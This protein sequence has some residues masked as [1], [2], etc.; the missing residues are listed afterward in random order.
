MENK[1]KKLY[2]IGYLTDLLG[3]THRTIRYYEQFGLLPQIK[4]TTGNMRLFDEE[5]VALIKKIR[6][7]QKQEFLPLDVIRDRILGKKTEANTNFIALMDSSA[8][9]PQEVIDEL[10]IK[11]IPLKICYE[12]GEYLDKE[13]IDLKQYK[14]NSDKGVHPQIKG[15][16]ASDLE[17]I[18]LD[19]SKKGYKTIFSFHC[20]S[21]LTSSYK[22]AAKAAHKVSDTVEV[23]PVDTKSIGIG[24]GLYAYIIATAIKEKKSKEEIK[25]ILSKQAQHGCQFIAGDTLQ[26]LFSNNIF[27]KKD[28]VNQLASKIFEFKPIISM[29][30]VS[31]EIEI[32]ALYKNKEETVRHIYE[33]FEEEMIKRKNYVNKICIFY[34]YYYAEA[35]ELLNMI[36]NLLPTVPVLITESNILLSEFFGSKSIG[37]AII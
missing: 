2:K 1:E 18:F 37:V 7:M 33:L 14:E 27:L 36:N 3:I 23:I 34:D 11:I 5:D 31:G 17:K 13:E 22:N 4:R 15:L 9:L 29:R 21:D 19:L 25:H 12:N 8:T 28:S 32:E 20:S 10:N 24:V 30:S 35:K 26:Y 16:P 6:A